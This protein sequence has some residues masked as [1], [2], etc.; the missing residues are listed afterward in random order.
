MLIYHHPMHVLD[1]C[2]GGNITSWIQFSF[3]HFYVNLVSYHC[4]YELIQM[5]VFDK[6][7]NRGGNK[8]YFPSLDNI[9]TS[10]LAKM[11]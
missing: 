3:L 2:I 4:Q 5:L 6:F 10:F 9:Q 11:F 1:K 7:V 8:A